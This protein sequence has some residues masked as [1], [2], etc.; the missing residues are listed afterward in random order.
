VGRIT[1]ESRKIVLDH[2]HASSVSKA[3]WPINART[4]T[5]SVYDKSLP[6]K[7]LRRL[8]HVEIA[9]PSS[10][11]RNT[12]KRM[13]TSRLGADP[14]PTSLWLA[15]FRLR[16]AFSLCVAGLALLLGLFYSWTMLLILSLI[17][18]T[19]TLIM[20]HLLVDEQTPSRRDIER[21]HMLSALPVSVITSPTLEDTPLI[22]QHQPGEAMPFPTT[23][24][25]VTPFLRVLETIDLSSTNIEHFLDINAK[26]NHIPESPAQEQEIPAEQ[27]KSPTKSDQE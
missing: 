3:V 18:A 21:T 23:P 10:S 2:V 27:G 24:M 1:R 22:Q 16:I 9:I 6:S 25:P 17:C 19:I 4:N 8:P 15:S 12:H 11:Q 7:R 14:N 5:S 20:I 13:S 26:W